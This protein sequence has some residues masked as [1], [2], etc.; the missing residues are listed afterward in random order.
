VRY[1]IARARGGAFPPSPQRVP[2]DRTSDGDTEAQRVRYPLRTFEI[3]LS[4][5]LDR[6]WNFATSLDSEAA[7]LDG[8]QFWTDETI[9]RGQMPCITR[10]APLRK[11]GVLIIAEYKSSPEKPGWEMQRG[12]RDGLSQRENENPLPVQVYDKFALITADCRY[13]PLRARYMNFYLVECAAYSRKHWQQEKH[14]RKRKERKRGG[15]TDS[16]CNNSRGINSDKATRPGL[17]VHSTAH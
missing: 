17:R 7:S 16:A 11:R 3:A 13:P 12:S 6:E 4:A 1:I 5:T 2:S 15:Q 10:A 9:T 8:I 14:G